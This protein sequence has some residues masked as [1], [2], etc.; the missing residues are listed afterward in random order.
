MPMIEVT[1]DDDIR[2]ECG[3][4][5]A[6]VMTVAP[7]AQTWEQPAEGAEFEVKLIWDA[8]GERVTRGEFDAVETHALD[9][10]YDEM[11]AEAQE[12]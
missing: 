10:Y 6:F 12:R 3:Y 7:V 1:L 2:G 9:C 11:L 5:V 4:T 8:T